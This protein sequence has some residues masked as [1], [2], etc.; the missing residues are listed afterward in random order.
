MIVALSANTA[1]AQSVDSNNA[2]IHHYLTR[3]V[4]LANL[5]ETISIAAEYQLLRNIPLQAQ[6]PQLSNALLSLDNPI[7]GSRVKQVLNGLVS[8]LEAALSEGKKV[9]NL[10]HS[11][12]GSLGQAGFRELICDIVEM[13]N[14]VRHGLEITLAEVADLGHNLQN[15]LNSYPDN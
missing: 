2:D 4:T 5:A 1:S 8:E 11:L 9:D 12:K 3:P 14:R 15:H 10:L 13:E 6:D 7:A